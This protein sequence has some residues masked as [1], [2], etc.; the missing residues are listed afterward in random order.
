MTDGRMEGEKERRG[1]EGMMEGWNEGR[2]EGEE[3]RSEIGKEFVKLSDVI[4]VWL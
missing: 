1:M 4:V 3:G 2:K